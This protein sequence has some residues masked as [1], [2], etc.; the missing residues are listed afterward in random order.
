MND[1]VQPPSQPSPG[2]RHRFKQAPSPAPVPDRAPQPAQ[3]THAT[4]EDKSLLKATAPG[5]NHSQPRESAGV[6]KHT[7]AT[8]TGTA[9]QGPTP[10]AAFDTAAQASTAA[11]TATG[12]ATATQDADSATSHDTSD[13][14]VVRSTGSMAIATLIS[15]LTGFLR[16]VLIVTTLGPAI[17]SAFNVANTLP[18]L[19]TE[20]VLGAVLTSLVVPVLVRAEKEDPDRGERFIRQLF[21][22]ATTLLGVITI[23]SVIGAPWLTRLMLSSEGKVNVVQASSFAYL[24]LPQII[25]YGLFALLMAVLNTKNVFRPG[26]W[27]PVVNNIIVLVVLVAYKLVPGELNPSAPSPVS[28]PHVLLLG[29]GTTL[30]VVVQMLI[31]VP[32]IRRA[33]ISLKPLWGIDDRLKQFGGMALAIVVYVAISQLGYTITTRI[34]SAADEAAPN[35]YQQAWLLLQVPYGI[36]GVTL[37]TAIMPRLSR[38]AADGDD[39]AV[40]GDL[41]LGSKLTFL[42]LIPIVVFFTAFGKPIATGLFAYGAFP[43]HSAGILGMTLSFS[44]FT[45][46]PYAMVLLHLRVFYAREDAWTPTFIIAGITVTKVALSWL[47]P[48]V[49]S[50]PEDVVVLLGAANGFG[51]V[52][53]AVIGGFLLRRKLGSLGTATIARTSAWAFGAS[54]IGVA[55]ALV[56]DWLLTFVSRPLFEHFGSATHVIHLVISGIVFLIVT[57]LLLSRSGLAEVNTVGQALTRIPGMSRII[58]VQAPVAPEAAGT[59]AGHGVSTDARVNATAEALAFESE[60]NASPVPPPMSAGVVRGPRLIPGAEVSDGRFRLLADHGSVP[61]ARFWQAREKATGRE[62]ALTFVD[63]TGMAPQAAASPQDAA[64]EASEVARRTTALANLNLVAVAPNIETI[65]YRTGT[66]V[67]ADWVPGRS[68]ASVAAMHPDPLPAAAAL[69]P[70]AQ[71]VTTA[72]DHMTLLGLDNRARIRISTQGVA[73]LA[74]PAVLSGAT[75]SR[76]LQSIRAMLT[77]LIPDA[78]TD[79]QVADLLSSSAEDLP[80]KLLAL[81]GQSPSSR[82]D[83]ASAAAPGVAAPASSTTEPDRTRE[84]NADEGELVGVGKR[85]KASADDPTDASGGSAE[86]PLEALAISEEST[87]R[88]QHRPGFG[89]KGYSRGAVGLLGAAAVIIVIIAA[90]ITAYLV[91]IFGAK[92][93]ATPLNSESITGDTSAAAAPQIVYPV[94]SIAMIGTADQQATAAVDKDPT[95]SWPISDQASLVLTSNTPGRLEAVV[96]STT[97]DSAFSLKVYGL[98]AHTAQSAQATTDTAEV[99]DQTAPSVPTSVATSDISSVK[100]LP[101][102][103]DKQLNSLQST[104]SLGGQPNLAGV[105]LVIDNADTSVSNAISEITLVGS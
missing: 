51:F 10:Q 61:G 26:A 30:G 68:L 54:L 34:A 79:E 37:L 49:A 105:V 67:V 53:G 60:F 63:T 100:D 99:L 72:F 32:P 19:I 85:T 101:L 71:A 3:E 5:R 16:N 44:A 2:R 45:L 92:D 64:F 98:P 102:L 23:V 28:D 86:A 11:G 88:P 77:Q 46:L 62:V 95:T 8:G 15:R 40:V 90:A 17:S 56:V 7:H 74:F 96:I 81:A 93:P 4:A 42:A 52:A 47:A 57:G 73:T 12:T 36:I 41:I 33:G 75:H 25:F 29:L 13:S 78:G 27:A 97:T 31:M 59:G 58:K 89:S 6:D 21:T 103:A 39:K 91:S 14:D 38:N 50:S 48:K 70:L 66:L 35:I 82:S 83:A 65:P 80:G 43:E 104:V 9:E 18:N 55:V 24:L 1:R 84:E 22:L 94:A 76:D 20:I 87:P 69:V